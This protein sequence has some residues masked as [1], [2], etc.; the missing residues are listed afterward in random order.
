MLALTV[1]LVMALWFAPA[2]VVFNDQGAVEA[3]KGSFVGCLRNMLPFLVYGIIAVPLAFLATLP[4]MLGWLVFA[5]VIAASI[6]V[7]YRDIYYIS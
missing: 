2:L 7:G 6:Y 4:M 5:P 3:M 1:P